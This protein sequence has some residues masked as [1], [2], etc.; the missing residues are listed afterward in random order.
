MTIV[1]HNWRPREYQLPAWTALEAG[2]KRTVLVWH[3][4]AGKDTVALNWT[5][6]QALEHT[7]VY[8]HIFPTAKQGR[9]ILWDGVTK[10]GR[11]FISYWPK[12]LVASRNE[13]EMKLKLVNGSV[14][15][16]VGSD[17]YDEA[18]IGGNPRGLV[19][20]EYALQN[21]SCWDYLRPILAENGGWA[22]FPFTPRGKN[23]G[24]RLYE[25]ARENAHNFAQRLTVDDTH[26][27][28]KDAIAQERADGMPD[29]LIEQ[30]FYCS[31]EAALVG[32][33]Y[34]KL[35]RTAQDEA[36]IA[37]VPHEPRLSV[38][39]WWDLGMDDQTAIWFVQRTAREI[40]V[41]DYYEANGQ[42]L[43][44][45][46]KVLQSR[47]YVYGAAV[48]PHD[49]EVR[50][51]GAPG[52]RT[53][54]ETL[55]SL[56][57]VTPNCRARIAPRQNPVERINAVRQILPR[58]Y[59]DEKKCS[60]GL[61]ALRQYTREWDDKSKTFRDAPLHDWTSHAADAFGHGAVMLRDP[62]SF[63]SPLSADGA[64]DPLTGIPRKTIEHTDYDPLS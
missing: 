38:E 3:R 23:H 10:E 48:L 31:F 25:S 12:S 30:E 9:K 57:V 6:V 61:E 18:L 17:N 21:P 63:K 50:E 40:R 28:T 46:A 41:I 62:P 29:E 11:T 45:Y 19:L 22:I 7:G 24:W 56:G 58:C 42:G 14:W 52:G 34:G 2:A 16:I 59:F 39:T 15:Q 54:L 5:V 27:I 44:H 60:V 20:S 51:L 43:D 37:R 33:Y 32:S 53:R 4:R 49:V 35:L 26:V 55:R 1:P 13:S 36:R 8:W 47:P 64:Y